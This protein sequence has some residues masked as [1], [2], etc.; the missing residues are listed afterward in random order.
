MK[1]QTPEK[2]KRKPDDHRPERPPKHGARAEDPFAVNREPHG[3]GPTDGRSDTSTRSKLL[4]PYYPKDVGDRTKPFPPGVISWLC[5]GIQILK[6]D[7]DPHLG[8]L[9]RGVTYK[10]RVDVSNAGS[11][12]ASAEVAVYWADPSAG[13]GPPHLRRKPEL[14]PTRTLLAAP[15]TTDR[16]TTINL[17]PT[18]TTPDHICLLA[19]VSAFDDSPSGSWNP[20]ADRHYAQ[21]N[22]DIVH[23]DQGGIGTFWFFATNPLPEAATLT[24]RIHPTS[25]EELHTLSR[26]FGADWRELRSGAVGV[27]LSD[28]G[29][30]ERAD[31]ELE[32]ELGAGERRLCQGLVS[33]EGLRRGEFSAVTVEMIATPARG[34]SETVGRG[35]FGAIVFTD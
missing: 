11:R 21:H 34:A 30:L 3:R 25:A 33:A 29:R 31:S 9:E 1:T 15:G 17:T 6:P 14:G 28:R 32:I 5:E 24:I 19:V 20:L 16:T 7:G 13:F 27:A 18:A 23:I 35:S 8:K 26:R 2:E 4:I 10:V 22:V 12:L